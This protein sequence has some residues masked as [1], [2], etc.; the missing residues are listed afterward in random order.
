MSEVTRTM[1]NNA[2]ERTAG[3]IVEMLQQPEYLFLRRAVEQ[4]QD[5]FMFHFQQLPPCSFE[6]WRQMEDQLPGVFAA[7]GS[8]YDAG[9]GTDDER[10]TA[11]LAHNE[12]INRTMALDQVLSAQWET[13][14]RNADT[15]DITGAMWGM[16]CRLA[17]REL[18]TQS[19]N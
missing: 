10:Y 9:Q 8:T 13:I 3:R 1:Y 15:E 4:Q 19:S 6:E 5:S 11:Y 12:E 17:Q 14:S 16:A 18:R 7:L 2:I